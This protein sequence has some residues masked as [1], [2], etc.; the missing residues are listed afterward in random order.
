MLNVV[1]EEGTDAVS[2]LQRPTL[3]HQKKKTTIRARTARRWLHHFGLSFNDVKKDVYFDG[4]ERED[5]IKYRNE[6]FLKKWQ[7]YKPRFVEFHEDGSSTSPQRTDNNEKPIVF[8]THDE[9]TFNANDAKSKVWVHTLKRF[10]RP[11]GRGRGIMVSAFLTAG[12]VLEVPQQITDEEL[13]S[14]PNYPTENDGTPVRRAV[15][16]LEFGKDN[17]WTAERMIE[18]TL[19]KALPIFLKAFP[20]YQGLW[21]FDNATSHCAFAENALV[22][23]RVRHLPGGKQPI[24]RDGCIDATGQRQE[25]CFGLD[26]PVGELRGRPKGAKQILIERGLWTDV[27][28]DG[29]R[30]RYTCPTGDSFPGC[31]KSGQLHNK[32][33]ARAILAS[34]NDF[35]SQK[36]Y[37]EEQLELKGQLAMFYPKFHCE[38]NFIERFWC[39][40]KRFAR[41]HCT[42]SLKGLRQNVPAAVDSVTKAT[43][44]RHYRH[45]ERVIEAYLDGEEYGTES[46]KKKVYSSH[47]RIEDKSRW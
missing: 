45:C 38:M 34:Q 2:E 25:M 47:R 42:Y 28:S 46:F 27:R 31:A 23:S 18:D 39:D 26:H 19:K 7:H 17:Y 15:T 36:G 44:N 4:H 33:C 29:A 12:G 21:A 43:I 22:A 37:L 10:I 24:M 41:E 3:K 1:D 5:V 11:K 13:L 30:M 32:C 20:E 8:I 6:V 35:Q 14:D 40:T 9:S 16:L